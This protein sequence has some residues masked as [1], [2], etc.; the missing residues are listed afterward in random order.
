VETEA[1]LPE[2]DPR[3]LLIELRR[4]R[5]FQ[6]MCVGHL[7]HLDRAI[8]ELLGVTEPVTELRKAA[9]AYVDWPSRGPGRLVWLATA[10][11]LRGL[12]R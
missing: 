11:V 6:V 4:R 9:V 7:P 3:R 2:T 5:R 10:K 12:V 8:S 1:L